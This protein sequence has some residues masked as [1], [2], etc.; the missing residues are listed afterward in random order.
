MALAEAAAIDE[1][2]PPEAFAPIVYEKCLESEARSLVLAIRAELKALVRPVE[3]DARA[4]NRAAHINARDVALLGT[5]TGS[6][7][8]GPDSAAHS[9]SPAT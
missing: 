9:A 1:Q 4:S 5:I 8:P 6:R 2:G 7:H 3:N